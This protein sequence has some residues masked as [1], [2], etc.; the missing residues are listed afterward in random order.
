ME[1]FGVFFGIGF[2]LF[3]ILLG[4]LLPLFA[5]I[6]I[7]RSEFEGNNKLMWVLI[8][9]FVNFIGALLYFAIGRNQR[10]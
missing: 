8:V 5:L 7:V 1:I 3:L 2:F 10:I 9:V 6:D 4:M